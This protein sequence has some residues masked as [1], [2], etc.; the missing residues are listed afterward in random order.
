VPHAHNHL[1]QAA[2][3]LGLPGA[4]AYMAI[5]VIAARLM[6]GAWRGAAD[7]WER[8][9]IAGI[10]ASLLAYFIFGFTDV[11]PLGDP[12]GLLYWPLL[13]LLVASAH[14]PE[15]ALIQDGGT[16]TNHTSSGVHSSRF[17]VQG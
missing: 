8:F 17:K 11:V 3:D 9:T 12:L 6:A 14:L 7:Q 1:L 15:E 13:A 16:P 10:A 4:V 2:V 5:W